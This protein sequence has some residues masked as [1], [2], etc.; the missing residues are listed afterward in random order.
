MIHFSGAET[1]PYAFLYLWVA[2]YA[3]YFFT[4]T[5]AAL[6]IALHRGRL[7]GGAGDRPRRAT[8]QSGLL[9]AF[10]EAAP[11]WTFTVGTL[12][13]AVAF[14]S[15]LK[16]RLDGLVARFADAAREDPVTGLRNRR[17]FDET[18]DL[19]VER[20]RRTGRSVSL[21]LGDLDHFKQVNDRFGHPRGDEVLR[22]TAR[23][24]GAPT[25]G[26]T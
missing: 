5:K 19:E 11:R 12:V 23:S 14:V 26:S 9:T 25:G 17:G 16:D 22:R 24:C 2:L 10:G 1:S 6:H 15:L 13:V 3:L 20:A 4:P 7:R 18:F 8:T 21:V